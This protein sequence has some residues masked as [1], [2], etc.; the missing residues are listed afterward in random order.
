[1]SR[2]IIDTKVALINYE[3]YPYIVIKANKLTTDIQKKDI[4][5]FLIQL[6][7]TFKATKGPFILFIDYKEVSWTNAEIRDYL[8]VSYQFLE[9]Q[10][11]DRH[12][13]NFIYVPNVS[14]FVMTKIIAGFIS[15]GVKIAT[16][17]NKERLEKK[18]R[19]KL[20]EFQ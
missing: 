19:Q 12:K 16:S 2:K 15:T 3:E 13:G 1:M 18:A 8:G 6:K 10:Y 20:K 5:N 11:L 9:S 4:D 14:I 17:F 7:N